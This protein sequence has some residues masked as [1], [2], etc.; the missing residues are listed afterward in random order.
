MHHRKWCDGVIIT[1]L[2]FLL[3]GQQQQLPARQVPQRLTASRER[4][5]C[6]SMRRSRRSLVSLVLYPCV[7]WICEYSHVISTIHSYSFMVLLYGPSGRRYRRWRQINWPPTCVD[8]G[9]WKSD[10]QIV[11]TSILWTWLFGAY[12][13]ARVDSTS[14]PNI[15]RLKALIKK[16]WSQM[17]EKSVK[18]WCC[19]FRQ[20]LES[21]TKNEGSLITKN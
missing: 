19:H 1:C 8:F 5:T 13:Q 18:S 2:P 6:R 20:D 9:V 12:L 11:L 10:H 14:H 3:S 17:P 15:N 4:V 16:V 7:C 21:L